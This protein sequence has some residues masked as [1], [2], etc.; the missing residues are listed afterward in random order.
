MH[1]LETELALISITIAVK[2][3]SLFARRLAVGVVNGL[4]MAGE[5]S[6]T[7][8]SAAQHITTD[9]TCTW[10]WISRGNKRRGST[11]NF[12]CFTTAQV[13]GHCLALERHPIRSRTN[14]S[15]Y[16]VP[17]RLCHFLHDSK[18]SMA[19]HSLFRLETV[20]FCISRFV[21]AEWRN[22]KYFASEFYLFS[23]STA[24]SG[25]W[26]GNKQ[27]NNIFTIIR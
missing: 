10:N 7:D 15:F 14:N 20:L 6:V 9:S 18:N 22:V 4:A 24:I 8:G 23:L 11:A 26:R 25:K 12:T 17:F 3:F 13:F 19:F 27:T 1:L 21:F 16:S 5:K 2:G